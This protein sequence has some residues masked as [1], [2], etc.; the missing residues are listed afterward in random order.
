MGGYSAYYSLNIRINKEERERLD[1]L[2]IQ[3]SQ[4]DIFVAGLN[5]IEKREEEKKNERKMIRARIRQTD[6]P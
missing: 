2:C 3:Y 4:H 1:K 6:R 5:A